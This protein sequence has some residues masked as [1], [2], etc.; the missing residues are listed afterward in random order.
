[1]LSLHLKL[2][3]KMKKIIL[4]FITITS[5]TFC[6]AQT[7]K[8]DLLSRNIRKIDDKLLVTG[9]IINGKA[10]TFRA[11][12]YDNKLN[13]LNEYEKVVPIQEF[14][15]NLCAQLSYGDMT[16]VLTG[17]KPNA[18][19]IKLT[20]DLKEI[21]FI[22]KT[23][24]NVKADLTDEKHVNL[25]NYQI[26]LEGD[27]YGMGPGV[28]VIYS[29]RPNALKNN[30]YLKNDLIDFNRPVGV[31]TMYKSNE[32]K[33]WPTYTP[34]W[35]SKISDNKKIKL[36]GF[37]HFDEDVVI[38]TFIIKEEEWKDFVCRIDAKT[39]EIN[40]LKE[41]LFPEANEVFNISNTYFDKTNNNLIVVGQLLLKGK[42]K[43]RFNALGILV[44]D[45]KGTLIHSK[46]IDFPEFNIEEP[47]GF[48]FEEKRVIV[49]AIGKLPNGNYFL[50]CENKAKGAPYS[51]EYFS[52]VSPVVSSS[53]AAAPMVPG[54]PS[55]LYST[56]GYSYYELNTGLDLINSSLK[57]VKTFS[58]R[59][60][61]TSYEGFSKNGKKVVY[62][63]LDKL[64]KTFSVIDF[65]S[66]N[67]NGTKEIETSLYDFR[68]L[69]K[70]DKEKDIF[71]CFVM[72]D[73][74][75][76]F[77]KLSDTENYTFKSFSIK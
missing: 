26:D 32:T 14:K 67:N 21:S 74:V 30:R 37:T 54:A 35:S 13:I 58:E 72:D 57:I 7:V 43:D 65:D 5:F 48:D 47:K 8:G 62:S 60:T 19:V 16:F 68:T 63:S 64:N 46:K 3:Q 75:I 36:T 52:S 29:S 55:V 73:H 76:I 70:D 40:F 77:R 41:A 45:S 2:K 25:Q 42:G 4:A 11:M 9:Y 59:N 71:S 49:N 50:G 33:V 22:E 34:L 56:V 17:G 38:G 69:K 28:G 1:M 27:P 20:R 61:I 44:F 66:N 6:E 31:V 10:T 18:Y 51:T 12:L 53:Q 15:K 39:G 24:A 23:E